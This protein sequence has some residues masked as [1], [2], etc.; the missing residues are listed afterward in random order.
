MGEKSAGVMSFKSDIDLNTT[1]DLTYCSY[2]Q[3]RAFYNDF[4]DLVSTDYL[5]HSGSR[6]YRWQTEVDVEEDVRKFTASFG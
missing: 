6:L 4:V 5:V 2:R 1:I 3:P